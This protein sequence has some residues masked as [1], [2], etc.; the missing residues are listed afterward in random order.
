[1][2]GDEAEASGRDLFQN[3]IQEFVWRELEN[4]PETS[5]TTASVLT[6]IRTEDIQNTNQMR[7]HLSHLAI[8]LSTSINVPYWC[9]EEPCCLKVLGMIQ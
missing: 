6:G 9:S 4:Q 3:I 7:Y 2:I 8:F 1:L 5:I